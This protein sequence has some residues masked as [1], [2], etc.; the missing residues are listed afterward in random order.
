MK[1]KDINEI[2]EDGLVVFMPSGIQATLFNEGKN[3]L[4]KYY[5]LKEDRY[6][7]KDFKK[8]I[9]EGIEVFSDQPTIAQQSVLMES[10]EPE[11]DTYQFT[12]ITQTD[13]DVLVTDVMD[14]R[15][16]ELSATSNIDKELLRDELEEQMDMLVAPEL[17]EYTI[18]GTQIVG[19]KY[20][21]E[22]GEG[23]FEFNIFYEDNI[24]WEDEDD[25]DE[26]V[27]DMLHK[28]G[29][30]RKSLAEAYEKVK[31][32]EGQIFK[33]LK[34]KKREYVAADFKNE[35]LT[36]LDR[37]AK[38]YPNVKVRQQALTFMDE[39]GLQEYWDTKA[40]KDFIKKHL[41]VLNAHVNESY[42][43]D[44]EGPFH[45]MIYND[46]D[47]D[48]QPETIDIED[49]YDDALER[50]K[51]EYTHSDL[52]ENTVV[53]VV[54]SNGETVWYIDKDCEEKL[55]ESY[56]EELQ[57]GVEYRDMHTG[58]HKLI[59][60]DTKEKAEQILDLLNQ[61][62]EPE[63][64]TEP[65]EEMDNAW[66]TWDEI[67]NLS[68]DCFEVNY[69]ET[70]KSNGIYNGVQIINYSDIKP[71][72]YESLEDKDCKDEPKTSLKVKEITKAE[73]DKTPKDYKDTIDGQKYIMDLDNEQ[74]ATVLR[75]CKIVD[76]SADIDDIEQ[77][78]Y[79]VEITDEVGE[80]TYQRDFNNEEAARADFQDHKYELLPKHKIELLHLVDGEGF[81][82]L[83]YED[84]LDESLNEVSD[85]TA[86]NVKKAREQRFVDSGYDKETNLKLTRNDN[87]YN[88]R[89]KSKGVSIEDGIDQLVRIGFDKFA[90]YKPSTIKVVKELM[91]RAC[92]LGLAEPYD[93]GR[94]KG[95]YRTTVDSIEAVKSGL[96][97]DPKAREIAKNYVN[98]INKKNDL[99][100]RQDESLN[101]VSQEV[102]D[103]ATA[104]RKR[105]VTIARNN[106]RRVDDEHTGELDRIYRNFTDKEIL[107]GKADTTVDAIDKRYEPI[108]KDLTNKIIQADDKLNRHLELK[109]R[110][111][112]NKSTDESLNE[113]LDWTDKEFC[114]KMLGRLLDDCET[115]L[116]D[117]RLENLWAKDIDE[118]MDYVEKCM[119]TL[120]IDVPGV[121]LYREKMHKVYNEKNVKNKSV[122]EELKEPVQIGTRVGTTKDNP[123]KL[124]GTVK[125]VNVAN[126]TV[127][128][129]VDPTPEKHNGE[130]KEFSFKDL[131]VILSE[132]L[133]NDILLDI[134]DE[135]ENGNKA[136]FE[137][138]ELGNWILKIDP[139]DNRW[140]A[141]TD[142]AQYFILEKIANSVR[143]GNLEFKDLELIINND[144]DLNFEDIKSLQLF[145]D[146]EIQNMIDNDTDLSA[147]CSYELSFDGVLGESF[148]LKK[149]KKTKLDELGESIYLKDKQGNE[150]G[151]FQDQKAKEQYIAD[152]KKIGKTDEYEE[153]I[154]ED[155]MK[156]NEECYKVYSSIDPEC[157]PET[158]NDWGEVE[159]HLYKKWGDY[160]ASLAKERLD[161]GTEEDKEEFMGNFEISI[162]PVDDC[163]V[164][165]CK[166]AECDDKECDDVAC[167][168]CPDEEEVLEEDFE[169]EQ[170]EEPVED[171]IEEPIE[172][173]AEEPED[174]EEEE[175]EETEDDEEEI[176]SIEDAVDKVDE[177]DDAL[178]SLE[179]FL[180]TL[181][182]DEELDDEE[183]QEIQE[184]CMEK[185]PD[186]K[187]LIKDGKI[188]Q[189]K[190]IKKAKK[191]SDVKEDF[192]DGMSGMLTDINDLDFPDA[193]QKA[194][195]T[196]DDG[197]LYRISDIAKEVEDLKSTIDQLKNDFKADLT[198]MLQDLKNDLK[199]SVNNVETKVQDTKSAVDNLTA[200][201]ED[202][203]N[204]EFEEP[205]AETEEEAPAEEPTEEAPAEE[206]AEEEMEEAVYEKSL[207]GNKMFESIKK[208]IKTNKHPKGLISINTIAQKLR[209][210]YGID[211]N[212]KTAFGRATYQQVADMI[213]HTSLKNKITDK[214]TEEAERKKSELGKAASWIGGGLMSR[215]QEAA[216][217]SK[218]ENLEKI[219]AEIDQ[220]VQAGADAEELKNEITMAAEDEQE[221]EQAKQYAV[222]KLNQK[223]ENLA[224][225]LLKTSKTSIFSEMRIRG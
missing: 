27:L 78:P 15:E 221:E 31:N 74:H 16:F 128:V 49:E 25:M 40:V 56:D 148:K 214:I 96:I 100:L 188:N 80:L 105:N 19:F 81:E 106:L 51:Y 99:P 212:L 98:K 91:N 28:K 150:I 4:V 32:P 120:G 168:D 192:H 126:K 55:N 58:I 122:D 209:E 189:D 199:L 165:V 12:F 138:T 166:D 13:E 115:F 124:T 133:T 112:K 76:E 125:A 205:E 21:E 187:I 152:Q 153:I 42:E 139:F 41:D 117:P 145:D 195:D 179:D 94:G 34:R 89:M 156:K 167:F 177:I 207:K 104:K 185:L 158:F 23:S 90:P 202:I 53:T 176:E 172:D 110:W 62:E 171:T 46:D 59:T 155:I 101:E 137:P 47:E 33:T 79:C 164:A 129:A 1:L 18:T 157:E 84:A 160:K 136:G 103:T 213:S 8:V 193:L 66:V 141:L 70:E 43:D 190:K 2:K 162:E 111:L 72:I 149:K 77:F 48:P 24:D 114:D 194:V 30:I 211:A 10:E 113:E 220:K 71:D 5:N 39:F 63:L 197:S 191:Q 88:A 6:T 163:L 134:A 38:E 86:Y 45:V 75:P 109:K 14:G 183:E 170:I 97:D 87:L 61:L 20:D 180:D 57:Y 210:D 11:L 17:C 52:E 9:A 64:V 146:E 218:W 151:P 186:P 225:K 182:G 67:N 223:A 144:A 216:K 121:D 116:K 204:V 85:R 82:V 37:I 201:E 50:A 178:D 200:E 108:E 69:R 222:D 198:N 173:P 3:I 118:H 224:N 131:D 119:K 147:Y 142:K 36:A 95:K 154:K 203:E 26:S 7:I 54:N 127:T 181:I 132:A 60:T 44:Y 107:A 143:L 206:P 196:K 140:D 123:E 208:I 130:Q 217:K 73:W 174:N 169:D 159:D 35:V 65:N 92:E 161:F 102:V 22:T 219:K 175:E 184:M 135:I 68:T 93:F 29:F 215:L 83:D